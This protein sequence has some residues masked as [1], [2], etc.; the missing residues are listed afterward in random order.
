MIFVYARRRWHAPK[1]FIVNRNM[2][3]LGLLDIKYVSYLA[4]VCY[5]GKLQI[6]SDILIIDADSQAAQVTGE[7]V[8]RAIPEAAV[9]IVATPEA[10]LSYLAS[11]EPALVIIDP[12]APSRA[13]VHL[14]AWLKVA[15]PQTCSLVLAAQTK[16]SLRRLMEKLGVDEYLEK[17]VLRPQLVAT[18]NSL[19]CRASGAVKR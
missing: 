13:A 6:M 11:H 18:L 1:V 7:I 10:A 2:K 5:K 4:L 3:K 19:L 9:T 17:S 15:Y 8:A 12:Q 16:P 14:I